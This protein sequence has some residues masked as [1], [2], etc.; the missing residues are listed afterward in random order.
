MKIVNIGYFADGP[1]AHNAFNI[2]NSDKR[3]CIKFICVR[4]D[5]NDTKLEELGLLNKIK[6][7]KN[8]NVNDK[9]FINLL[10]AYDCDIF[11]SMSFNQILKHEIINLPKLKTINC[12]AGK[13]PF[14]RGRNVLNW[15]LIND[16]K[17]FGI[18]VHYIDEGIDTGPIILQ[19]LYKISDKDDYNTLLQKAYVE[20]GIILHKALIKI[21]EEDVQPIKQDTIHI[22]GFY[23]AKRK[24]GDEIINW[25]QSSRE[26]FCFIRAICKPGPMALT[27]INNY[28]IKINKA[29]LIDG[30]IPY[31]MIP[32]TIVGKY[33]SSI[34]VKTGDTVIS[35]DEYY[36]DIKLKIGDRLGN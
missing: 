6:I 2:I 14:Y 8:K 20:C 32:G 25:G 28:E 13:L 4:F 30:A 11:V 19:E 27:K 18:T 10:K 26:I 5:S 33:D 22:I 21:Y 34:I 29:S 23:C 31:K 12:H 24:S 16:E 3:F 36:S 35:I 15:V 17:E 1:W 9:D 7:L